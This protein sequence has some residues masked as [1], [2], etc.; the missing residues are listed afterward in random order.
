MDYQDKNIKISTNIPG[1]RDKIKANV[2]SDPENIYWYIKFNIPLDSGSVS[3]KTM[4]VSDTDGYLMR[5]E[6]AYD[7]DRHFISISPLDTYEQEVFYILRVSKK[8]KSK[9]GNN[10]KSEMYIVFKLTGNQVSEFKTLKSSAVV[11]PIKKRPK[12]YDAMFRE[13]IKPSSRL[14]SFGE[15]PPEQKTPDV[16]PTSPIGINVIVGVLGVVFLIVYAVLKSG[17]VLIVSFALCLAGAA[18]IFAQMRKNKTRAVMAYNRGVK[19]FNKEGY[20]KAKAFFEKAHRLDPNNE[21]AE[22]ALNKMFFYK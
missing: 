5:T 2:A 11:P 7:E 20:E 10:L 18:H 1:L 4:S 17:P 22:Y 19:K 3:D 13:K 12:N 15:A 16:L 6:I 14:Y 21:L 9:R 8:V